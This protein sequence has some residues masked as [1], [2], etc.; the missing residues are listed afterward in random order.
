MRFH[1]KSL[2]VFSGKKTNKNLRH[3]MANLRYTVPVLK[4]LNS[5][6]SHLAFYV[7]KQAIAGYSGS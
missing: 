6:L 4:V 7:Q 2:A 5:R 3:I 1:G